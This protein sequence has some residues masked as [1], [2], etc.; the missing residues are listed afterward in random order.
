MYKVRLRIRL[1]YLGAI[2]FVLGVVDVGRA[3]TY[4][5]D[6]TPPSI[7]SGALG[8]Q[9]NP[10]ADINVALTD[11][12]PDFTVVDGDDLIVAPGSYGPF[13]LFYNVLD[14]PSEGTRKD[15]TIPERELIA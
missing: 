8:S 7:P 13:D 6:D 12:S 4:Y 1:R 3:D 14:D 10:Y 2:V 15:V 5:V 9:G 11:G